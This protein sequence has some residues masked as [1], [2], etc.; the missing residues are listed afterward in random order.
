MKS[1]NLSIYV[2]F[3]LGLFIFTACEKENLD[4]TT[5]QEEPVIPE[6]TICYLEVRIA[7]QPPGSGDLFSTV[8][9]GTAPYTYAWSTG[10]ATANITVTEDGTY[11]VTVTDAEDCTDEAEIAVT[12]TVT[13]PCEGFT[14]EITD[15]SDGTLTANTL[16]GTAPYIYLWSTGETTSS[17]MVNTSI[18]DYSVTVTDVNGCVVED[19]FVSVISC[20]PYPLEIVENPPGT[21]TVN[22]DGGTAPFLYEWST[23]ATNNAI[24]VNVEG[25][26]SVTV[27]GSLG[28]TADTAAVVIFPA[29]CALEIEGNPDGLLTTI[30]SGGVNP[31]SY[32]WS[33]GETTPNIMVTMNGTYSVTV[34][35]AIGCI[36]MDDIIFD[37]SD[38][39]D[40]SN[41][42]VD[43]AEQPP[44]S[45]SIFTFVNGG[46]PPY[47]YNWSN[48]EIT[49]NIS[50]NM[51]GTYQLTITDA[52]GCTLEDE[53]TI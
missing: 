13:G 28:C 29:P 10:A 34:E 19:S 14:T 50:P 53:I 6:E 20:Q 49:P 39:C 44:G 1:I 51:M 48:G 22:P 36:V 11:A 43:L 37:G 7:E 30:M 12:V 21:L 26:Y 8:F 41:L 5:N 42:T 23:G 24:T 40:N 31:Y 3:V 45:G 25:Y 52:N 2:L 47:L 38:P 33:T 4:E 16:E 18:S 35:D 46:T 32:L 15:N 17:I 9:E 27:T